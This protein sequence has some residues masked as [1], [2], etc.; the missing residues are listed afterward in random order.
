MQRAESSQVRAG[1]VVPMRSSST[2]QGVGAAVLAQA[3][4]G[5]LEITGS[6]AHPVCPA[7]GNRVRKGGRWEEHGE[8]AEAHSP[9][10]VA[11]MPL[12]AEQRGEPWVTGRQSPSGYLSLPRVDCPTAEG[13]TLLCGTFSSGPVGTLTSCLLV[14]SCPARTTSHV[15]L[16]RVLPAPS[17][18]L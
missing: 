6:L 15:R 12:K 2:P 13:L 11:I 7:L 17:T 8:A 10:C 18:R 1:R 3:A 4:P 9:S 14:H 5:P 16:Y